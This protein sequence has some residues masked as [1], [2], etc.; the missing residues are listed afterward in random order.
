MQ[1]KSDLAKDNGHEGED[2]EDGHNE[3][4]GK[5]L[6]MRHDYAS[7]VTINVNV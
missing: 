7:C 6:M 2:D 3:T 1:E 5:S 4:S